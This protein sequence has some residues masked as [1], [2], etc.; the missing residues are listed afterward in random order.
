MWENILNKLK[1]LIESTDNFN[2]V[3]TYEVEQFKGSPTAIIV[4]S[5]NE[6]DY[7]SSN[8]NVRIYSFMIVLYV[9]RS[10][11]APGKKVEIEADRVMRKLIDSVI[12]KCDRNYTLTGIECPDGYTFIN[13]FAMPS[14]WGYSGRDDEYRVATINVRCRVLVDVEVIGE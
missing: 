12:D 14:A 4:P 6:N 9:N 10:V 8:E 1:E 3:E 7:Y 2:Q 13:L 11:T 5:S